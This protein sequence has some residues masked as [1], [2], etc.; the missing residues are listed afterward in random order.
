MSCSLTIVCRCHDFDIPKERLIKSQR[1]HIK[2]KKWLRFLW[3]VK[4][5]LETDQSLVAENA[6]CCQ[7]QHTWTLNS[8]AMQQQQQ[9]NKWRNS[10]SECTCNGNIYR[11]VFQSFLQKRQ[12]CFHIC[13][14]TPSPFGNGAILKGAI[15][16]LLYCNIATDL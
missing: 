8:S 15:L 3:L 16:F 7:M 12:L 1:R 13:S 10:R 6:V 11:V 5:F 14:C 2:L 9:Q 4:T